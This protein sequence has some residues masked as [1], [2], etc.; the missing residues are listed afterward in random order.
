ML[1]FVSCQLGKA[2][3][4]KKFPSKSCTLRYGVQKLVSDAL[5]L[6]ERAL[7]EYLPASNVLLS[8]EKGRSVPTASWAVTGMSITA[9]NIVT[10]PS[11]STHCCG[12]V[13][14]VLPQ[15]CDSFFPR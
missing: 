14:V 10:I 6:F 13:T 4:A 15:L 9:S 11:V 5:R 1:S 12:S 2:T 7:K 8:P 3:G